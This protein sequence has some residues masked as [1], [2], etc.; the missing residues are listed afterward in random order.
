[1]ENLK[2][3]KLDNDLIR[4]SGYQMKENVEMLHV[5]K[6]VQSIKK[7]SILWYK[8]LCCIETL[9]TLCKLSLSLSLSLCV[10]LYIPVV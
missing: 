9:K 2:I 6:S 5:I 1:M 3:T 4:Q 10:Y 8:N 7:K